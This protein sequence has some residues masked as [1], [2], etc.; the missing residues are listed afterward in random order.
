MTPLQLA[1]IHLMR[2]AQIRFKDRTQDQ[3]NQ[4]ANSL[5]TLVYGLL[6]AFLFKGT[7]TLFTTLMLAAA[8]FF[9]LEIIAFAIT[10]PK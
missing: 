4:F 7:T 6:A 5:R 8:A 9:I 10:T 1:V 2:T 3:C